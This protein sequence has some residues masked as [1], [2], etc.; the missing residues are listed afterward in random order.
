MCYFKV[1]NTLLVLLT[2]VTR[3]VNM[4]I[5]VCWQGFWQLYFGAKF[6]DLDTFGIMAKFWF[7]IL[8]E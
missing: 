4:R 5:L 1:L 6:D 8:R 2:S 3:F 7:Y